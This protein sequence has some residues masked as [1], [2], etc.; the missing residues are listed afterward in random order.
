MT[1][2][3]NLYVIGMALKAITIVYATVNTPQSNV[4]DCCCDCIIV[5]TAFVSE[6]VYQC[7]YVVSCGIS[8]YTV[9]FPSYLYQH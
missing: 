1:S 2:W 3:P 5:I 9:R 7:V 8:V 6:Y 4:P